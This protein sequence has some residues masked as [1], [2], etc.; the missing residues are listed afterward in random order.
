[1]TY[2]F[3]D[4]TAD[5]GIH[6]VTVDVKGLFEEA[7][8]ALIDILG[9]KCPDKGLKHQDITIEGLDLADTLVRWLQELLYL[10]EVKD[11]RVFSLKVV[12]I[13]ETGLEAEVAG[14]YAPTGLKKE[15]KAVTYH[16][17]DIQEV[18]NH[19]QATIIFDT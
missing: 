3:I 19:V 10:I 11:L 5:I 16:N 17:L 14:I 2:R 7:A 1:M 12:R 13:H 8:Y 15:I 6:I 18:D 4:H 9:A